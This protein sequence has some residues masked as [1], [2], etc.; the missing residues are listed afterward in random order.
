[1][2]PSKINTEILKRVEEYNIDV[3][4][5]KKDNAYWKP[6]RQNFQ[7]VYSSIRYVYVDLRRNSY[8]SEFIRKRLRESGFARQ[9]LKPVKL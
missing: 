3:A 2:N 7:N 4:E 1:M 6:V 8:G 9:L 5:A